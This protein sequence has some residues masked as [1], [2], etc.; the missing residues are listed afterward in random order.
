MTDQ[1][2]KL[3]NGLMTF[4]RPIGSAGVSIDMDRDEIEYFD[5]IL[6]DEKGRK[7]KLLRS[8]FD[9]IKILCERY[10]QELWESTN[11]ED[12]IW[13]IDVTINPSGKEIILQAN[14]EEKTSNRYTEDWDWQDIPLKKVEYISNVFE[15]NKNVEEI[16]FDCTVRYSDFDLTEFSLQYKSGKVGRA[17]VNDPFALDSEIF[18]LLKFDILGERDYD[19][20]GESDGFDATIVCGR[21]EDTSYVDLE[22]YDSE[23][24]KGKRIVVK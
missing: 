10:G 8:F 12:T 6:W 7:V 15:K 4:L 3:F 9:Y 16:I 2:R 22:V 19:K 20:L 24:R 18:R 14:Y 23:N 5:G 13:I 11:K 1:E 17:E 21:E